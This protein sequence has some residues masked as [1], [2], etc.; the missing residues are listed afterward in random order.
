[1]LAVAVGVITNIVPVIAPSPT[2]IAGFSW[3]GC[4]TAEVAQYLRP[5][6]LDRDYG[7]PTDAYCA[8]TEPGSG[9]F[10]REWSRAS[11]QMD[12][13]SWK[14]TITMKDETRAQ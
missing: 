1:L 13:N 6:E 9:V 14:G 3:M 8:E 5:A 10:T 4:N 11:V 12:C 2:V 7:E